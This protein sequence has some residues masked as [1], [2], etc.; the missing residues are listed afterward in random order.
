MIYRIINPNLAG[1]GVEDA[2]MMLI[3]KVMPAGLIG[4]VLAGMVS[5]TSSKANTTINMAA[6][7]FAQDIFKNLIRPEASEKS[8]IAIARIFTLIFGI[9]TILIA[10]WI[11][12]AGGI[13]NVVLST[14]SIAGGALFAPIIWS[15][16]SKRQTGFSVVCATIISLVVNL[17]LKTIAPSAIGLKL[18]LTMETSFGMGIPILILSA[19]ELYYTLKGQVAQHVLLMTTNQES[20]LFTEKQYEQHADTERQNQFGIR[21]IAASMA[22]VGIGIII[23]GALTTQFTHMVMAVGLTVLIIAGFIASLTRK[24]KFNV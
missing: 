1:L 20:E 12:S 2:Y 23:L 16:F 13:V 6:T 18:D 17:F 11:P 4:L 9:G 7:V 8:V 24:K 19:F 10:M 3:Q 22:V 21:V 14:A 5:A 15:L